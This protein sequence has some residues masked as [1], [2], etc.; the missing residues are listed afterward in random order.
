MQIYDGKEGMGLGEIPMSS[1]PRRKGV[2]GNLVLEPRPGAEEIKV[3]E[4]PD[5]KWNKGVVTSGQDGG[6]PL[7]FQLGKGIKETRKH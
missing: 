4:K 2:P 1:Q 6:V 7:G 3:K 5:T